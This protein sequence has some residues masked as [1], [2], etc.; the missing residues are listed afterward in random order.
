GGKVPVAPRAPLADFLADDTRQPAE[1]VAAGGKLYQA[2]CAVCHGTLGE[3]G[4]FPDLRRM[5]RDTSDSFAEIVLGGALK[6][7]GMASFADVLDVRGT[8][9][10]HAYIVDWAQRSRRGLKD[11]PAAATGSRS[12]GL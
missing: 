3:G 1:Q 5:S 8:D 9:A 4:V 7:G 10:I 6:A 12:L 11:R 2:H